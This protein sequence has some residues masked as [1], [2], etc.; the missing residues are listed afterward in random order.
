MFVI[1][2]RTVK[3]VVVDILIS[4]FID[5]YTNKTRIMTKNKENKTIIIIL[6]KYWLIIIVLFSLFFVIIL[7]LFV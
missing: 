1:H 2:L 6:V 4:C 7:V 3:L 5:N